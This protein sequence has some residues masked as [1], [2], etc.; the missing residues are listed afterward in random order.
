MEAGVG[1]ISPPGD[2]DRL[3]NSLL[4]NVLHVKYCRSVTY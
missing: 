3:R 2:F 1:G 4:V